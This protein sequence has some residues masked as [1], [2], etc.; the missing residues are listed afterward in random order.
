MHTYEFLENIPLRTNTHLIL[1]MSAFFIKK[2][3]A[4]RLRRVG[5]TKFGTN[6]SN[7]MLLNVAKY[8][9]YSFYR[10]WIIKG[11]HAMG[12]GSN[13]RATMLTIFWNL[14]ISYQIFLSK[15]VKQN[16]I[17]ANK[18]GKNEL[19]DELPKICKKTSKLYW[20]IV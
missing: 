17:T 1:L 10:F 9:D 20:I 11:K 8:Q 12:E 14:Q 2:I 6:V 3:S 7:E 15:K 4:L 19:N 13:Y 5:D 18:N 16:V